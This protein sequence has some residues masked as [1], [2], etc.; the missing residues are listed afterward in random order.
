MHVKQFDV[1]TAFLNGELEETIFM[2][3][4]EGYEDGTKRVLRLSKS[5]YGLKQAAKNWNDT[6][7]SHL[8]EFGL[9]PTQ[10]DPCVFTTK[11][12]GDD[13]LMVIIYV[14]DGVFASINKKR[15]EELLKFLR[16]K[17]E[18][19][20]SEFDMFLGMQIKRYD[21]GSFFVSQELYI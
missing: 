17:V 4:P 1:K 9:Y 7:V 19:T 14:D 15:I 18:I 20:T 2:E 8:R 13:Q 21:D 12:K 5:L 6:F 11:D 16:N 3:Q 10:S